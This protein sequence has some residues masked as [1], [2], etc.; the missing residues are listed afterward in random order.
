MSNDTDRLSTAL[1]D[2]YRIESHLGEHYLRVVPN[3][4]DQMKR[5]VDQSN[6]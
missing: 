4:V 5:A 3:W 6:R 1:A 2:R